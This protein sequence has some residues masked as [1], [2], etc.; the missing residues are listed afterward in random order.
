MRIR[1]PIFVIGDGRSGSTVFHDMLANHP[2]VAWLSGLC[3]RNP[4]KISRNR[5]LLRVVDYPILGTLVKRRFKPTEAYRF[6]DYYSKGFSAPCRDLLHGDVT[7]AA[8]Q[9]LQSVLAKTLTPKRD[10][11]LVKVT[12]WPRIGFLREVFEDAKFVH[13]MRDGRSVSNSMLNVPWWWGWRG[14]QNWRWGELTPA[15]E[16]EWEAQGKS[17]VALAGIQ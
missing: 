15:E 3:D 11:L 2:N 10:R 17:F 14:P 9:R 5:L 13:I 8:K 7:V 12:G 16:Q 4:A 6:W 1:K